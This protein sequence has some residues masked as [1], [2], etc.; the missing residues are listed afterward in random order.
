MGR[1]H[2]FA[3]GL[4]SVACLASGPLTALDVG[5]PAPVFSAMDDH[6]NEWSSKDH[7]GKSLIAVFFYPAAMTG[8]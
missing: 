8:G 3:A 2:N 7:V 4:A 6:G 5:D 1:L